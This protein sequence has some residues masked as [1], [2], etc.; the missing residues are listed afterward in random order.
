MGGRI[1]PWKVARIGILLFFCIFMGVGAFLHHSQNQLE[2]KCSVKVD[3]VI[4][5]NYVRRHQ[6]ESVTKRNGRI[7]EV[8]GE[9]RGMASPVVEYSY[10]GVTY[11]DT[12]NVS[13]YPPR[14]E[15]G[16]RVE[17]YL[18]PVDPHEYY[19]KGDNGRRVIATVFSAI[20]VVALSV[21]LIIYFVVRRKEKRF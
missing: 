11:R 4:V 16:Q 17:V 7:D 13:S 10:D 21:Y 3:G 2:K 12:S 20:G 8:D 6:H 5:E 19:I 15:Q 18:Y 14:Y 9:D 1:D